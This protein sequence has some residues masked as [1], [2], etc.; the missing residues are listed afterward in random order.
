MELALMSSVQR[1]RVL[2]HTT[3]VVNHRIRTAVFDFNCAQEDEVQRYRAMLATSPGAAI[4]GLKRPALCFRHLIMRWERFE[5]LLQ[6]DGT[7]YGGDRNEAIN[8]QGT[9][10]TPPESLSES[11]AGYL[12]WLYC[13]GD[14]PGITFRLPEC[15]G[16]WGRR[17]KGKPPV[18][19]GWDQGTAVARAYL[20]CDTPPQARAIDSGTTTR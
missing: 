2:G 17:P 8:Y 11:E 7:W 16:A 10:A 20:P 15:Q 5:R 19:Q 3:E 12:T 18:A 9:R 14:W 1:R 13:L 4:L 6:R